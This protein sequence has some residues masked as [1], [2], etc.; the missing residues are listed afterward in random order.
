[1]N[2]NHLFSVVTIFPV[3]LTIVLFSKVHSIV[4][5]NIHCHHDSMNPIRRRYTTNLNDLKK[6]MYLIRQGFGKVLRNFDILIKTNCSLNDEISYTIFSKQF[7]FDFVEGQPVKWT[8]QPR[9]SL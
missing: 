7:G 3:S 1:M 9:Q 8:I 6:S 4:V 5:Y 2:G